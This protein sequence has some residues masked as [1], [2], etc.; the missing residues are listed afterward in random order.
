MTSKKHISMLLA[1]V[2]MLTSLFTGM[3]FAAD[4]VV[5]WELADDI[6]INVVAHIQSIGD[7]SFEGEGEVFFGTEGK[8]KR[9]E[10]FDI[11][12]EDAPTDMALV[13][14]AHIQ[15]FGNMPKT[16]LTTGA[17]GTKGLAK[18]IEG[19][20]FKLVKKGTDDLYPD[21]RVSYQVHM[22]EYGW[23]FDKDN[24]WFRL[25]ND[26]SFAS[27]GV[28]AGT[29]GQH[30]RIEGVSLVIERVAKFGPTPTPT[31]TLKPTPEPVN[32]RK[33]THIVGED[34]EPGL[35]RTEGEV[36]YWAR[37]S[38][39]SGE[40]SEVLANEAF[41]DGPI[42]VE[43]L[44]TDKGFESQ[45]AGLWYLI[46]DSYIPEPLTEFGDGYY[47]VGKDIEPGTYRSDGAEYWARLKDFTG[48]I[49]SIIANG[50]FEEGS[51]IVKI[52]SSD[53]G[54]VSSGAQWEKIE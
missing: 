9:L 10:K 52:D 46:D 51:K 11:T 25:G 28:F 44:K 13:G 24:N 5:D 45:G 15:S 36:T 37:L 17:I 54:F 41:Q 53:V 6:T 38:G 12:L 31:P 7:K 26:D 21:Y 50:A 49:D 39:F 48:G 30:R 3:A 33:G 19:V 14:M 34:I 47:I 2:L 16:V 1:L 40:I 29:K 20:A 43:I 4:A 27:D 18:R 32:F 22:K 42:I 8:A 35:Y 23:G